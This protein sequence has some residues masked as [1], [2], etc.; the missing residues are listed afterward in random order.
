MSEERELVVVAGVPGSGRSSF[1]ACYKNSF[2][3]SLPLLENTD[4]IS[5]F[6]SKGDSFST[7]IPLTNTS[8][9]AL[10]DIAKSL[11]YKI[12]IFYLFS[13]KTLS[14]QRCRFKSL[15]KGGVFEPDVLEEEYELS[16]KG[17]IE[18]YEK[19]DLAFLINAQKE[20]KFISAFDPKETKK[21]QFIKTVKD[22]KKAVDTLR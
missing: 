10:L 13:G 9:Q 1:A 14:I 11:K 15:I 22:I 16:H 2:L 12:T 4:E 20:F 7:I 6:L 19:S 21:D 8:H 5:N 17:L 18:A 3:K